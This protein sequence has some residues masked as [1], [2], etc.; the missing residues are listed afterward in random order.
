MVVNDGYG[1]KSCDLRSRPR[2]GHHLTVFTSLMRI[3]D[4]KVQNAS[5][6]RE[7]IG[8]S[9]EIK[10]TSTGDGQYRRSSLSCDLKGVEPTD[11]AEGYGEG[12]VYNG[13][14]N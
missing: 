7:E 8:K 1:V 10:Q 2:F 9:E 6:F 5:P 14:T 4:I 11:D 3:S 13:V 12:E